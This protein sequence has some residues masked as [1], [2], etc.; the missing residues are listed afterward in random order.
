MNTTKSEISQRRSSR[1][2][3]QI[4]ALV[5]EH[6]ASGL[7]C[8]AYARK[9]GIEVGSLYGWLRVRKYKVGVP[10]FAAV[11][12]TTPTSLNEPAGLVRL[13]GGEGWQLEICGG[14]GADFAA[15]LIK[16]VAPCLR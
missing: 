10:R 9:A 11:K 1:S 4:E 15:Q 12:L 7:S 13:K 16:A 2:R 5:A 14:L 3:E 6:K 8:R